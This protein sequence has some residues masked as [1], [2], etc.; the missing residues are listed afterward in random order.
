MVSEISQT[1]NDNHYMIL[2]IRLIR[3]MTDQNYES[4]VIR[5]WR[6]TQGTFALCLYSFYFG[7]EMFRAI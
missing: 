3:G 5:G 2:L 7:D 1:Q 6:K 4:R